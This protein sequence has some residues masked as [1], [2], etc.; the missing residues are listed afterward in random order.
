MKDSNTE[1]ESNA[2]VVASV[3]VATATV[4]VDN[5]EVGRVVNARRPQPPVVSRTSN[6]NFYK[7]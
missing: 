4:A 2:K 7:I 5:P 1:A 6:L 3:V